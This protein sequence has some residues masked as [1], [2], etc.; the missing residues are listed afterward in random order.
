MTLSACLAG[1]FKHTQSHAKTVLSDLFGCSVERS[2]V[3][4]EL[5]AMGSVGFIIGPT[6]GGHLVEWGVGFEGVAVISSLIFFL[7]FGRLVC[8]GEELLLLLL[9]L[10]YLHGSGFCMLCFGNTF[11]L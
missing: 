10:L 4:G 2:K 3:Q 9:M 6:L 11:S 1:C 8:E 5:N 7:N